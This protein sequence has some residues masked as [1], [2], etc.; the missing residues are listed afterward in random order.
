MIPS[1]LRDQSRPVAR[2]DG[3][4]R[5]IEPPMSQDVSVVRRTVQIL[6]SYGL[7]L[8]PAEK[9]V[10]LA[11]RYQAEVRVLHQGNEFNGK[12][13]LDLM[14]L[15]AECGTWL[16]IEAR[17]PDA[18]ATLL[19]LAELVAARFHEPD[20]EAPSGSGAESEDGPPRSPAP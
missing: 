7:H 3:D 16:E 18:E 13:I 4:H 19:A 5:W 9:F 17:G 14:T 11:H 12:S 6:N 15:A 1:D 10:G 20:P 8:R 2:P